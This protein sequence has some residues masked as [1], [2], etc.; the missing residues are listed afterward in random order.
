V[1]GLAFTLDAAMTRRVDQALSH[2]GGEAALAVL[3]R[4]ESFSGTNA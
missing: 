2:L 4:R 3:S 1:I